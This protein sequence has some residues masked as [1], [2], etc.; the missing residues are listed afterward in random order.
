MAHLFKNQDY[1]YALLLRGGRKC[2]TFLK[3]ST[4]S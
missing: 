3:H 2:K 1:L 4:F